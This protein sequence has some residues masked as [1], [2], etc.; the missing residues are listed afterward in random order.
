M[1]EKCAQDLL[2]T[3]CTPIR[4]QERCFKVGKR[5]PQ[6][7]E[8]GILPGRTAEPWQSAKNWFVVV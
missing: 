7:T 1:N 4:N 3:F 6:E 8:Q 2:Q 5:T